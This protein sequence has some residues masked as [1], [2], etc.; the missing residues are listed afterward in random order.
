MA[1]RMMAMAVALSTALLTIPAFAQN[2]EEHQ[3]EQKAGSS[4]QSQ[5]M[6]QGMMG[7]MQGMMGSHGMGMTGPR[8]GMG[9]GMGGAG[10]RGMGMGM[11]S[12]MA[13]HVEGRIAFLKAE[14]HITDAQQPLWNAL[15]EAMR[16]DA[17][18]MQ[19]LRSQMMDAA[20]ATTP[21]G[22]LEAREKLLQA[23]L[24]AVRKLKSAVDPLYAALSNEQKKMADQLMSGPGMGMGRGMSGGA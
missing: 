17:K 19:G 3:A 5:T 4:A 20:Q 9:M 10:G 18:E 13:G 6:P 12:P 22:R 15:A 24:D 16:A 14:L 11:M 21:L 8:M 7:H 23:R 1:N 2:H